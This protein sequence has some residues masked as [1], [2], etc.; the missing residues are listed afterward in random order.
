MSKPHVRKHNKIHI[1][2]YKVKYEIPLESV[3]MS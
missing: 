1:Y 3:C 2:K